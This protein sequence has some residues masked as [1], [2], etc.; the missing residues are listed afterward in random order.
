MVTGILKTPYFSKL[1]LTTM[2]NSGL[3]ILKSTCVNNLSTQKVEKV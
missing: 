3:C 2:A 1:R